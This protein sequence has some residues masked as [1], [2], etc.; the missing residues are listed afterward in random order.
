MYKRQGKVLSYTSRFLN[1]VHLLPLIFG[2]QRYGLFTEEKGEAA[3]ISDL[4]ESADSL[5]SLSKDTIQKKL[6]EIL[7]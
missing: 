3:K 2:V 6:K 1:Y 4:I 7:S 5:N